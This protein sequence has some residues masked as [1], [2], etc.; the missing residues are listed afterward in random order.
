VVKAYD[1]KDHEF[2]RTHTESMCLEEGDYQFTIY[3]SAGDGMC[4]GP[5]G[6]GYYNVTS[7]GAVIA[8]G[9]AF[10]SNETTPFQI[11]DPTCDGVEVDVT[12]VFD[13][14]PEEITW[15]IRKVSAS[16]DD[17][18]MLT[19]FDARKQKVDLQAEHTESLCLEE[20]D[21]RF[22]IYDSA[23]DGLCCGVGHGRDGYYNVTSYGTVIAQGDD[24]RGSN[25]QTKVFNLLDPNCNRVDV[26]IVFDD[27]WEETSWDIKRVGTPGND[28]VEK[29][30]DAE[31]GEFE[32]THT[33]SMC[34]EDGQYRFTI[35]DD[36]GD[37]LCCGVGRKGYY[38]VTLNGT[39]IAWGDDFEYNETTP[40]NISDPTA[41][42]PSQLIHQ[43]S[44]APTTTT[45][46]SSETF[47][48]MAMVN[49][50]ST[51]ACPVTLEKSTEIDSSATLHYAIVP[52]NPPGSGNGLLCGRLEAENDGWVGLAISENGQ[53][54]GSESII[55]LPGDNTVLKYEMAGKSTA[56]VTAM[57]VEK[58]TLTAT[59]IIQEG[60]K[61]I[62]EFTKLLVED[63]EIPILEQ[64]VNIFL[65][66]RGDGSSL[67]F[68]SQ[69]LSFIRD[70][71]ED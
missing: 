57:S 42:L 62:M 25:S 66:A 39:V 56:R 19:T 2:E 3:D 34:L 68:H 67:G 29:S 23:G 64:G 71:S 32:R 61:T 21:Y 69:G 48:P 36:G 20:G 30:Y 5:E 4:C 1:A 43:P 63:G 38:N 52:S 53:M 8:Q 26:N 6:D 22:T 13:D 49:L 47:F 33:E 9:D 35:Y 18:V 44:T 16:G 31:D 10:G 37:G 50:V 70:F 54:I 27:Y 12:I 17:S 41:S 24:F 51:Q 28:I 59:S 15:D 14:D 58:Q 7:Y 45:A 46:P 60:G 65:H 55:G 11:N 40:F